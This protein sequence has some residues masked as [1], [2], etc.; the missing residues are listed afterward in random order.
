MSKR[1]QNVGV[2]IPSSE[3]KLTEKTD[4]DWQDVSWV[5]LAQGD[6]VVDGDFGLSVAFAGGMQPKPLGQL[7][8]AVGKSTAGDAEDDDGAT[9]TVTTSSKVQSLLRLSFQTSREYREFEELAQEAEAAKSRREEAEKANAKARSATSTA[10]A[11]K[12]HERLEAA[13]YSALARKRSPDL[14][15]PLLYGPATLF[16]PAPFD[17]NAPE[18]RMCS[19]I[20]ALCDPPTE[21]N[22]VGVWE[23]L[24]FDADDL[25][26]SEPFKKVIGPRLRFSRAEKGED[27]N[28][29]QVLFDASVPRSSYSLQF[30]SQDVADQ[31]VRDLRVR[32]LVMQLSKKVNAGAQRTND[33]QSE[34]EALREGKCKMLLQGLLVFFIVAFLAISARAWQLR[35]ED[36]GARPVTEY[37]REAMPVN[38]LRAAWGAM[39]SI[40]SSACGVAFGTVPAEQVQVCLGA[41]QSRGALVICLERLSSVIR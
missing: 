18:V 21:G 37:M 11:A 23:F 33:L 2:S 8:Q 5:K 17:E 14:P 36:G 16:G 27:P 15:P 12:E 6:I 1:F 13:V 39:R 34:I 25:A 24:F 19:G 10:E 28:T 31:F 22:T 3:Q 32:K 7:L 4:D 41:S 20:A 35:K 29:V 30:E 38:A 26:Q 9:L 40:G